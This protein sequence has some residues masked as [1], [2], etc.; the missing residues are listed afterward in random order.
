MIELKPDWP[1]GYARLGNALAGSGKHGEAVKAYA[2]GLAH[3]P[4][5][6]VRGVGMCLG[7]EVKGEG[8]NVRLG[9][10]G[11]RGKSRRL[12]Q[13]LRMTQWQVCVG[14]GGKVEPGGKG[15]PGLDFVW[16]VAGT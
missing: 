15:E 2:A 10:C 3:D 8:G 1:K 5:A 9:C 4:T 7:P 6:G 16:G 14:S 12:R 13:G 11:G